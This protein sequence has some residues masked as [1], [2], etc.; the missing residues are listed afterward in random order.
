M[1]E[2]AIAVESVPQ[3]RTLADLP[4]L[5]MGRYPNPALIGSCREGGV[6]WISSKEFFER[7]R[8]VSLGLVAM[9]L[10][11]GD[12][13]VMMSETRAD[14]LVV[15]LAI[16][17]AGGVT[18]PIYPTLSAGQAEY[19]A[20]DSGARWAFVST[21]AQAAKLQQVRDEL[22]ALEGII[23]FDS[24]PTAVTGSVVPFAEV[25]ARGHARLL[26]E[27]GVA[28]EYKE[29]AA[30]I[31]P[32]S[33]ATIIYTSGTTGEPK[34]VMLTHRNIVANVRS[35]AL[36]L[37]MSPDDVTFSY[38]P[39]SHAFERTVN[40][41]YLA[42]GAPIAYAESLDTVPR[43]LLLA[44]PTVMT[45]VPRVFEKF[46]ARVLQG[47][48]E[49]PAFNRALFAW[50]RRTG[51]RRARN[52][53]TRDA[54][55]A[56]RFLPFARKFVLGKI[57]A[58]L[59]GRLRYM[60][61]GSAPLAVRIAEFFAAV[62]IPI[63]EGYGLTETGPV[64]TV[65]PVDAPKFGTVGPAIA[66][67]ELRIGDDGEI[68]ARGPNIMVG[69]FN[70][71][72]A[73]AAVLDPDGWFHT[74]DIGFIDE[75]GYLHITDRKKDLIVTSG[76]KKLAPQPI[77]AR[78]KAHPLVSEAVLIGERRKYPALLIVPDFDALERRLKDLGHPVDDR[79]ALVTRPDVISLYQ[80]LV[81][82]LNRDLSQFERIKKMAI[83]PREFSISTGE[84]TP[85]MKVK[86]KAVEDQWKQI[87]ESMYEEQQ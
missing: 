36:A 31:Q 22:P 67:V 82:S 25:I 47:V 52:R 57:R 33:L 1:A 68:L 9:G 16:L 58:R 59:G 37:P 7:I 87:I 50:A 18:V 45:G 17:T 11:P 39:L 73:T 23:L 27:W 41:I 76:G 83:L 80:E 38:L 85:T 64:L 72:D 84:L 2:V 8:D 14:W 71:P 12:R 10:E 66:D 48:A 49:Q 3:I 46:Y 26:A 55:I 24:S 15:D 44:R 28:R 61:S 65:N 21:P 75:E 4:F 42:Q 5:V 70:K 19:I 79:S 32:E 13:V 35:C 6:N 56:D 69:Y 81:D 51:E 40:Y 86:R 20:R 43:D 63:I 78:L 34:G 60:V 77:E 54:A 53:Q 74:G 30:A 62:G 29:R